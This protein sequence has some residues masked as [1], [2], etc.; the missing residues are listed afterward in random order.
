M[1]CEAAQIFLKRH[2]MAAEDVDPERYI[3]AMLHEMERGLRGEKCS[4]AMIPAYLSNDGSVPPGRSAVVI[5]AGGTN[6]RSALVT[7]TGDGYDCEELRK[8][9]MPGTDKPCTWAEFISFTADQI[10]PLLDRADRIGFCFSYSAVITPDMDGCVEKVDKEVVIKGSEGQL[11]AASLS[12]ELERRGFTGKRIV[13]LN[14]TAAVLLGGAA[15]LDKSRYSGFVGQVSGTGSNTCVSLPT[16]KI[17]KLG[18]N[19]ER[20]MVVNLESG[21]YDG[22]EPG[23]FDKQLDSASLVPGAKPFEKMTAGVYL[24]ELCRLMLCAA[25][26]EG[27]LS[28]EGSEKVRAMGSIDSSVIDAWASGEG[29]E[30]IGDDPGDRDFAQTVSLA[31]FKRAARLMCVNLVALTL[32]ADA[33]R[34]RPMCVLAE[35]SLVDRGRHF[36]PELLR[37]LALHGKE[38][39]GLDIELILGH[40]STL[41][42]S[43]AAAL[44]NG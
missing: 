6:F 34:D 16:Y 1:N 19:S 21:F 29:F 35:G 36:R 2:G 11:I 20:G 3:D 38:K 33:G 27:L 24:G 23:D 43:A 25:A 37:Q 42:G 31:V 10:E 4:M 13:I 14:D 26:E 28:P 8:M 17:S 32:L 15:S 12:A 5:D 40:G 22:I 7:F 44:L 18:I 39:R 9:K 41:P 30:N